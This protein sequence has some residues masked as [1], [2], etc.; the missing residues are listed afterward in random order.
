MAELHSYAFFVASAGFLAY[1]LYHLI[2]TVSSLLG[3]NDNDK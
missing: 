1:S 3:K 2:R